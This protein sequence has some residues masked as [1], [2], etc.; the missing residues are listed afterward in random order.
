VV[1]K[2]RV[3]NLVRTLVFAAAALGAALAAPAA[4]QGRP[5]QAAGDLTGVYRV[6]VGDVLDIRLLGVPPARRSTL[7]TVQEGGLLDYPL[8]GKPRA[9]AGLTTDEIAALLGSSFRLRALY[10]RPP[11]VSVSVR[12]YASHAVTVAGLVEDPGVKV[13]QR[14]A[15]PLYVVVAD[16]QPREQAGSVVI[17][18]AAGGDPVIVDLSDLS[19]MRTLVLPGD[20]VTVQ[21][22]APQFIYVGGLV[23]EPGQ[24]SFSPGLTLS[25]AVLQAGGVLPL[26]PRPRESKRVLKVGE[27][28]GATRAGYQ[29]TVSRADEAGRL[30]KTEYSLEEIQ[31]GKVPDP[32]LRPGDR[33]VVSQ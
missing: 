30:V 2:T 13:I 7:F 10:P 22:Q 23:R 33:V 25:Q 14:E 32:L 15:I 11:K 6:G 3:T 27:Q 29:L 12:E 28:T 31:K 8:A 21:E 24:K 18:R 4:A 16:A 5:A 26:S 9:V 19:A 17:R 1:L 20:T